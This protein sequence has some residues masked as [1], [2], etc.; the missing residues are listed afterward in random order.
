MAPRCGRPLAVAM[1]DAASK[2]GAAAHPAAHAR[3]VGQ[4]GIGRIH[5]GLQRRV[6]RVGARTATAPRS[7][8]ARPSPN[9]TACA[10]AGSPRS[11]V[12]THSGETLR[13]K[14]VI[15]TFFLRPLTCRKPSASIVPRSPVG[16]HSRR[17]L[18]HR[19]GSRRTGCRAISIS[20]S[21]A[22]RSRAC[23]SARPALPGRSAPGRLSVCTEA[24]SDRP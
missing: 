24:P 16:H 6:R 20:P 10:I 22:M 1:P 14:A 2:G 8:P 3:V 4:R 21:A 19:P 9:T 18:R 23:G 17:R 11:A 5:G 13:P 7:A 12:S 15:S